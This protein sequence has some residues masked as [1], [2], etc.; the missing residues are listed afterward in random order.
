MFAVWERGHTM[1][2][3]VCVC[4]VLTDCA[5]FL[6]HQVYRALPVVHPEVEHPGLTLYNVSGGGVGGAKS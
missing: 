1:Y 3:C 2:I 6:Q 4:V 5:A